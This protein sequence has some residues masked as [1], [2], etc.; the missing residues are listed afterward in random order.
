MFINPRF[1]IEQ[2]WIKFP[3]HVSPN[4]YEKYIQPNAIDFTVDRMYYMTDECATPFV[5]ETSKR[6]PKFVEMDPDAFP[7]SPNV[8]YDMLSD[9]YVEVPEGVVA[10]LTIRSSFSRCGIRLSSGLYDS[11]YKGNIGC[12]L[13][14]HGP[15]TFMTEAGTRIAQIAFI[16]SDSAKEYAGGWNRAQGEDWKT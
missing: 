13:I 1:A 14:N 5:T 2:G 12:T 7:M 3:R 6:M 16:A 10:T 9:F 11:G 4:D 15:Q 8:V